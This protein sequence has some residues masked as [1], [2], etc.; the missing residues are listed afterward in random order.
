MIHVTNKIS[1]PLREISFVYGTSTGP[2][3]QHVNKVATKATL[4][5]DVRDSGSLTSAQKD[6]VCKQLRTRV[7]K[8]GVLRVSSSKYKSQKAN[9][10]AAKARFGELLSAVLTVQ[11]KRKRTRV[12]KTQKAKRLEQKKKQGEKKR[13]RGKV[14]PNKH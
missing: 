5:F 6:A 2:G 12:S 13:L 10:E 9:R 7:N 14:H 1:I 3:G 8:S 11:K 4:L